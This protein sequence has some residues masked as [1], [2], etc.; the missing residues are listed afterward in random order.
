MKPGQGSLQKDNQE[1]RPDPSAD[2]QAARS[3]LRGTGQRH[4]R[5]ATPRGRQ[6]QGCVGKSAAARGLYPRPTQR[7]LVHSERSSKRAPIR[8]ICNIITDCPINKEDDKEM[9]WRTLQLDYTS[10]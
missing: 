8:Y 6:C 1:T 5:D 3:I 4:S 10:C 2:K 9:Q 7:F